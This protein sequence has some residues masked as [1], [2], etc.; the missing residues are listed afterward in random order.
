[1]RPISHFSI[2]SL[3]LL[4]FLAFSPA[5][6]GQGFWS[7]FFPTTGSDFYRPYLDDAKTPHYSQWDADPWRPEDWGAA[8]GSDNN[9]L[10]GLYAAGIIHEQYIERGIPVLEVGYNFMRLSD[11]DK[12]RVARFVDHA[13]GIT[14]T[15]PD[16]IFLIKA[17][18][19]YPLGFNDDI[20]VYTRHGLQLQ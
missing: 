8:R 9:V 5:Q 20:A 12:I 14:A 19:L 11:Q 1:M 6:A 10:D 2:I 3:F 18:S 17:E 15:N 7:W 16:A 13:F 4:C